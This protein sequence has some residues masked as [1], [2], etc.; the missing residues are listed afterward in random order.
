MT[1][2]MRFNARAAVSLAFAVLAATLA[3]GV[4]PAG[5]AY[6]AQVQAGTLRVTGDNASDT[7]VLRLRSGAPDTLELDVGGDGTADFAFDR[8]TFTSIVV[9]AGSGADHVRIDQSN[10][11]FTDEDVVIDG[12]PGSDTLGG[13]SGAEV[14][15]GGNGPDVLDG[16]QGD[17]VAFLGGGGDRFVWDPGDGSDVV[18]GQDGADALGFNGNGA[19]ESVDV[20]ANGGRVRL[21]RNVAS[22]TMDLDDVERV[23]WRASG[24][25]DT[26]DVGDMSGTDLTAVDVDLSAP[27]GGGDLEA[28][29]VTTRGTGGPD[30]VGVASLAGQVVVSG[31]PARVAVTGSEAAGDQVNVATLGGTDDTRMGVGV[32]GPAEINV[33]GGDATDTT[34]YNG[35]DDHHAADQIDVAANG[36]E[37]RTTAPATAPLDTTAVENLVVSGLAGADTISS[38]GN[39]AA[40]TRLTYDGGEGNDVLRGGNGVD[41]LLGGNGNDVMDGN[42]SNDFAFLGA[43]A[44]RFV[45]DPGDGNDTIEGQ[46]G[47]DALDFNGNGAPESVDV[48]ANGG[49][50]RLF[51]NVASV[52]MDLDDV[53]RVTWRASGGADTADV[54]DMSGTDLTAVDIDLSA[55]GGGGDLEADTVTTRGT[56][57]ADVVSVTRP[58]RVRVAGLAAVTRILGSEWERDTLRVE[59]LGG[60]DQVSVG[61]AVD[62]TIM[63]VVDLGADE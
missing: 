39:L 13:G 61:A 23:T 59:T 7:L 22:V 31:L 40:L 16:N 49:R 11:S 60:D 41:V 3:G 6:T 26:A 15:I 38:A 25:A 50:V 29:I 20:A 42:Q 21:F 45:W 9:L 27:G 8:T 56:G 17:D 34:R 52:T 14:L 37:V 46:E 44:D 1:C 53:E 28:D 4:A 55:P 47:A 12:G 33:D 57:A 51:R 5:A 18:E 35:V 24:G 58:G 19:P 36:A 62:E 10:G 54:G 30:Q 2:E 43:G 32:A 48:A 63:L